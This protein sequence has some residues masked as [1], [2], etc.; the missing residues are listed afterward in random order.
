MG[1]GAADEEIDDKGYVKLSDINFAQIVVSHA[2]NDVL[3]GGAAVRL[4]FFLCWMSGCLT[5]VLLVNSLYNGAAIYRGDFTVP[6]CADESGSLSEH[7]ECGLC[8]GNFQCS[9]CFHAD[10]FVESLLMQGMYAGLNDVCRWCGSM[11]F[12]PF[13]IGIVERN[14]VLCTVQ[15]PVLVGGLP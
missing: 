2:L 11:C 6:S 14:F 10:I 4:V 7:A 8:H 5:E 3:S 15:R 1:V 13:A 9:N 12:I